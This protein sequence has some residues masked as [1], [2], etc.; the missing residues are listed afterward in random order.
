LWVV[1]VTKSAT[2]KEI[3]GSKIARLKRKPFIPENKS[4]DFMF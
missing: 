4:P 1:A 2:H 3:M